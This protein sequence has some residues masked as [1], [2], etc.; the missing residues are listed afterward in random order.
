MEYDRPY[1]TA[2]RVYLPQ[3]TNLTPYSGRPKKKKKKKKPKGESIGVYPATPIQ[4]FIDTR[5]VADIDA[6]NHENRTFIH[7]AENPTRKSGNHFS[8][9]PMYYNVINRTIIYKYCK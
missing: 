7:V 6:Q 3:I 8:W 9:N 2:S 5:K 1:T 4:I